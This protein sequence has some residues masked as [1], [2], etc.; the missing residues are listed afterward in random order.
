VAKVTV[1]YT[2]CKEGTST[3]TTSGQ[4]SGTIV[5]K[6]LSGAV[7]ELSATEK[8]AG[9]ELK[10]ESGTVF[11]EFTCSIAVKVEGCTIGEAKPV[12]EFK[13]TGE[14]LF[15]ENGAKTG[16]LWTKA[17]GGAECTEKAFGGSAWNSDKESE[18]FTSGGLPINVKLVA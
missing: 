16:Q 18:S 5:T 2:G 7:V 9:M 6:S 11:A 15:E 8:R 17:E 13:S 1:T 4:A 10:P 12:N 3:C 14:L